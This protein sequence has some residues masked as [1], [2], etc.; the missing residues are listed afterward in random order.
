MY[1]RSH[2]GKSGSVYH[3]SEMLKL[4]LNDLA[5]ANF[6]GKLVRLQLC[7]CTVS[8]RQITAAMNESDPKQIFLN[9][10]GRRILRTG[11]K[12][13]SDP[14]SFRCALLDNC[15]CSV[16][17]DCADTQTCTELASYP[18]YPVCKTENEVAE[19][20]LDKSA[21]PPPAGFLNWFLI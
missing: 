3:G 8:Y 16:D 21:F 11:T 2:W 1:G 10:F 4:K 18:N 6:I 20:H 5:R 17:G 19:T 9:D 7:H 13:N 12:I 14:S 15:F